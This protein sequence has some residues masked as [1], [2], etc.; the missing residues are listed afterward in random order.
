V[1]R[2]DLCQGLPG[3]FLPQLLRS[4]ADGL[5]GDTQGHSSMMVTMAITFTLGR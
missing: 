3:Q 4:D 5:S 1:R 2:G